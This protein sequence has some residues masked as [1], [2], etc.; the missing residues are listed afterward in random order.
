M[1]AFNKTTIRTN[2]L[3]DKTYGHKYLY[4]SIKVQFLG[5]VVIIGR[6]SLAAAAPRS[7]QPECSGYIRTNRPP[8]IDPPPHLPATIHNT[9]IYW[10]TDGALRPHMC[11]PCRHSLLRVSNLLK[12]F[13][14]FHRFLFWKIPVVIHWKL[15]WHIDLFLTLLSEVGS[16]PQMNHALQDVQFLF[17]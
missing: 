11:A 2:N 10:Y 8:R 4:I 9:I 3:D 14:S 15:F 12:G 1:T 13:C 7:N 17:S 16:R 6:G 5:S